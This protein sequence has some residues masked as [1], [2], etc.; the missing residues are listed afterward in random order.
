MNAWIEKQSCSIGFTILLCCLWLWP[1]SAVFAVGEAGLLDPDAAFELTY[2][3]KNSETLT[4]SWSIADGYYLYRD[5]VK[6]VS[7]TAGIEAGTPVLP[8]G[9]DKQDTFF[10]DVEIY[11][12][13]VTAQ[14]PLRRLDAKTNRLVID[15]RYQGCAEGRVC[16]LPIWKTVTF[17]LPEAAKSGADMTAPLAA[18]PTDVAEPDRIAGLLARHSFW[19]ILPS[20]L[21]FGLLLAFTPCVFPMIPIISG[22]VIGD[23]AES[24]TRRAFSLSLCYVLASAL[25]YT[26]F[27]ILAGLFG[28]NLQAFF[29]Q[30]W[31]L[32][33]TSGLFALL[34]LS[35]FGLFNLQVPSFVQSRITSIS[36][37]Q[38]RGNWLSAAMMGI[39]SALTIGPCVTAPLA[40]ALIYIGQSGDALLGGLALFALGLGMGLPLLLIGTS[41]GK[42]LPR[43]G[44][45]LHVTK[46]VFGVGLLAVAVWLLGRILPT[47]VML[48]LWGLLMIIPLIYLGWKK[49]WKITG[50]IA[51][52]YTV[53]LLAGIATK[54]QRDYLEVLCNAAVACQAE[55]LPY[56]KVE[57]AA[58]LRQR[59]A[60]AERKDQWL[61]LD[62]HADW[63][64]SCLEM[65][66]TTFTD[67]SVRAALST[68][69]LVQA[70]VTEEGSAARDLLG[71]FELVG[72]PA[73]L[74]FG[75]D[76]RER[77]SLRVIGYMDGEDFLA[78]LK[79][80]AE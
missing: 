13:R 34:A 53:L 8:K 44:A 51:L 20:F 68:M 4:F 45:W 6:F 72:P 36:S 32:I 19:L 23:G 24:T 76:Q 52:T 73:I 61:M 40:G 12:G 33:G 43:S 37:R 59:L 35:M 80:L 7:Q 16:Y 31:I 25:T 74:F 62:F 42:L 78:H 1:V 64:V 28:Q 41:A 49:L 9:D 63:C 70:D 17:D 21:G 11:R 67:P 60:E 48:V 66:N 75:P 29:Q 26:V 65:Q 18:Q 46:T 14:L 69:V 79:R 5:K 56:Q 71:R 3:V 57:T 39:L 15:L 50:F 47:S 77:K 2:A 55:P 54:S 58:D 10:G 30:P 38:R 27:G 22:I